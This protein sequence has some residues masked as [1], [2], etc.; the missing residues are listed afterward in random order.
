MNPSVNCLGCNVFPRGL[1]VDMH[2]HIELCR[3]VNSLGLG[4]Q[5][6][7]SV[8]YSSPLE[9]ETSVSLVLSALWS[10]VILEDKFVI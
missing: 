5:L 3:V 7:Y 1:D 4:P 2:G 8:S 10:V 6:T 9:L